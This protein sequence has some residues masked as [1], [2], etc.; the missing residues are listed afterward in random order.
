LNDVKYFTHWI[1]VFLEL[2]GNTPY[3]VLMTSQR[4]RP[5]KAALAEEAWGALFDFFIATRNERDPVF[6][7]HGLTPNDAKALFS[8]DA[9]G[10]TMGSLAGE[11]MCDASNA[12]WIVDRLEKHGLAE[13]RSSP[14]DRRVKMVVLTSNGAKIREEVMTEMHKPPAAVYDLDRE[15]LEAIR[16]VARKLMAVVSAP[17]KPAV[18]G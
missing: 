14:G 15:D 12:T 1:V 4:R 8:L 10:K 3:D 16:D 13:R 2:S 7:K 11:W 17:A 9:I 5:G 18:S 6:A